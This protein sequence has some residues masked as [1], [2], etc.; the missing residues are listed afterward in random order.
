LRRISPRELRRAQERMLKNLGLNVEELGIAQ[1]VL[2]RFEDNE[3]V[4]RNPVVYSMKAAGEQVFQIVG[5]ELAEAGRGE[6]K[7]YVP[8]DDDV[9]LV[10]SQTGA[11]PDE[12]RKALIETGGD[13]AKAILLL[14]AGR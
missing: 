11:S 6:V 1:E 2:I 14:R 4:I 10:V 7:E 3:L 12:A 13:L 9:A 5:G 8:S